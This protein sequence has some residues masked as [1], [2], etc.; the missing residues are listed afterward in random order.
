MI[1]DL[2]RALKKG[3]AK[4]RGETG[5]GLSAK[6]ITAWILFGMIIIVMAAFNMN[7][8]GGNIAAGGAAGHVNR[9][10]ISEADVLQRTEQLRRN[11]RFDQVEPDR[12]QLQM[13]ALDSLINEELAV[14]GAEEQ[15]LWISDRQV[16]DS[17]VDM[18][19]FHEGGRFRQD[20]YIQLLQA[21]RLSVGAFETQQR[22]DLLR[23]RLVR[24]L[25]ASSRPSTVELE[26]QAAV[27]NLRAN[28][29]FIAIPVD[30]A[31]KAETLPE[32]EV[33]AFLG[34]AENEKRVKSYYDAR[35]AT[36]YTRDEEV[37]ARHILIKAEKGDKQ[38]EEAALKKIQAVRQRLEK[39][40]FAKV[41]KEVSD[42]PGSKTRGGELGFFGRGRMVEEFEKTAFGLEPKKISEPVQTSFGFHLIQVIEKRP[43]NVT[44]FDDAKQA[45][46]RKLLAAERSEKVLDEVRD[47]A[48]KGD[49][50]AVT[51]WAQKRGLKWEET[52][53][54]SIEASSVP[55]IGAS[56]EFADSAFRLTPEKPLLDR[57]IRQ[58]SNV[59]LVRYKA[60]PPAKGEDSMEQLMKPEFMRELLAN[61]RVQEIS[62]RW[63]KQQR[64]DSNVSI[65]ERFGSGAR[66]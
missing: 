52:G 10:T 39:E 41:A 28:T 51:Q 30:E 57:L 22:R 24:V 32:A 59:Y 61:Q 4:G 13:Q 6:A 55:K 21:N 23:Q 58:G 53:P 36:E 44:E 8:G 27:Q 35:K 63:L 9:A 34:D 12:A 46:A 29:E 17:I 2:K 62:G 64:L 18:E 48:K 56:T 60:V 45:I 66:N 5:A 50:A 40:D 47:M 42:D 38:Q 19:V 26:R 25:E 37:N 16:A 3:L 65:A 49:M 7:Q 14:Q 15:G 31:V 33:A 43:A 20:K 11:P 54:F 1:G